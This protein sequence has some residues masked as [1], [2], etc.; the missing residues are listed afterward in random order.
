MPVLLSNTTEEGMVILECESK[1]ILMIITDMV[2]KE[3]L[4]SKYDAGIEF[5]RQVHSKY[6]KIPTILYSSFA[7]NH[8][9]LIS[10]AHLAGC[11]KLVGCN[12]LK[13]IFHLMKIEIHEPEKEPF[14]IALEKNFKQKVTDL[15]T[16]G[17][18]IN[19][20]DINSQNIILF[21]FMKILF[22]IKII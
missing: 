13:N 6:P 5:I 17:A 11:T 22:L 7:R 20:K 16:K 2:R 3:G 18:D 15:I 14:H 9:S 4:I 21:F 19:E 8:P 1:N 12:E 10:D